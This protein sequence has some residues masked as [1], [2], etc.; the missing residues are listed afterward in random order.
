MATA[1]ATPTVL[2]PWKC[3][4]YR[5][6]KWKIPHRRRIGIAL[7]FDVQIIIT[8]IIISRY[9]Q[10][11]NFRQLEKQPFYFSADHVHN[12]M[13]HIHQQIQN[14]VLLHRIFFVSS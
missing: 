3:N 4:I 6:A 11:K 10:L 12:G 8:V 5:T 13:C 1:T 2:P 9:T 14:T 7:Y